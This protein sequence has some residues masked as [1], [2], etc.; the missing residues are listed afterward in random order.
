MASGS[1]SG[2]NSG[3]GSGA[4]GNFISKPA[5]GWLYPDVLISK[6]GITYTVRVSITKQK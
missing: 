6:E 2:L 1:S 3:G 5:R 4:S